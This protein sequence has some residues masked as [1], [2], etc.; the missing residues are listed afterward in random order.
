MYHSL[1]V[2]KLM[3]KTKGCATPREGRWASRPVSRSRAYS[4]LLPKD[5]FVRGFYWQPSFFEAEI[6]T[7]GKV[8]RLE[9]GLRH[10][11]YSTG[12]G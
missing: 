1:P 10:P 5:L 6:S 12:H 4:M 2:A 9:T 7:V 3:E 11:G 8:W